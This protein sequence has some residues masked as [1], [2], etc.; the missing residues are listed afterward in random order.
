MAADLIT[1]TDKEQGRA[2]PNVAAINKMTYED[3]NE[4]KDVVNA[5]AGNIDELAVDFISGLI[6]TPADQ[7]YILIT[8][9]PYGGIITETTTRCISG[10][11]TATFKIGGTDLGGTANS[12]STSEDVQAHASDNTFS[13]G[14]RILLVVSSNS[15]CSFMSFTIKFTKTLA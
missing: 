12:V 8:N 14:N 13:S 6:E 15:S 5:H 4:I 11:C 9:V 2:L 1:Y 10:T 3:A 7:Q